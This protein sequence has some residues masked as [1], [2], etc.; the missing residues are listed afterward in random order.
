MVE[1]GR[2]FLHWNS[3]LLFSKSTKRKGVLV[4]YME[5][6]GQEYGKI[7]KHS[8]TRWLSL[9]RCVDRTIKNYAGLKSYFLSEEFVDAR[10]QRLQKA[11]EVVLF[12][13]HASIPLFTSFNMLLQSNEPLIHNVLDSVLRL[14][15]KLGNR[16]IKTNITRESK[17]TDIN[18]EDQSIYIAVQSIHLGGMTKFR[19]QKL[20][21]EGDITERKYNE[22]FVAAQ[23]YFKAALCYV[24]K[25]F[26]VIDEVLQHAKCIDVQNHSEAKWERF[27][28]FVQISS[29]FPPLEAVI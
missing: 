1:S 11:F 14:G 10:V 3:H 17:L 18:L 13:H 8:S 26:P 29:Q 7:L 2:S 25:K 24:L 6:C 5:F 21:S 15:K 27:E 28:F 19:L 12:F 22:I 20:L 16:I 23:A 9:E 4:E